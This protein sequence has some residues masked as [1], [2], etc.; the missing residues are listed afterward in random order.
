CTRG[1]NTVMIDVW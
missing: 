1:M